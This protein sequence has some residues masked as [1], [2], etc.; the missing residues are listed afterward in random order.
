MDFHPQPI[1]FDS[2]SLRCRSQVLESPFSTERWRFCLQKF[3]ANLAEMSGLADATS[4]TCFTA[5]GIVFTD[6]ES[7]HDHYR[8]EWHRYNLKRK[9]AGLA[10]L[11]KVEKIH[12]CTN[13]ANFK[14]T[15]NNSIHQHV[16]P[17]DLSFQ[18][19]FEAR[20]AAAMASRAEQEA[21]AAVHKQVQ[22]ISL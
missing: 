9:V 16:N 6:R 10:P 11:P 17:N 21:K 3:S 12:V 22:N 8:S 20:R 19:Q 18:E 4:V 13:S 2:C 5:P 14:R 7:L 1:R 15:K